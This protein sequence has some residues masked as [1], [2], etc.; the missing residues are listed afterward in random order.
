MLGVALMTWTGRLLMTLLVLPLS[1]FSAKKTTLQVL[2]IGEA[3]LLPL[4]C[5]SGRCTV[6][7]DDKPLN[8]HP[9]PKDADTA[10]TI[11][12]TPLE[13]KASD[14][15]KTVTIACPKVKAKMYMELDI[16]EPNYPEETLSVNPDLVT[17]PEHAM[18]RIRKERKEIATA[19]TTDYPNQPLT[20]AFIEPVPFK[21]VTSPFGIRR[22]YNDQLKGR[23]TGV[24]LRA[25]T[26]TPVQA[27]HD[28][29]V[30]LS[31]SNWYTGGHII[32]EHGWGVTSSYFHLSELQV[33]VGDIIKQGQQI[34]LTGATGRVTGPHLHWGIHVDGTPVNPLQFMN[35]TQRLF[36][37]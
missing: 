25:E 3:L 28:G 27:P 8:I 14:G 5:P 12:G 19:L 16:A 11:I 10:L 30:K 15:H 2:K 24:D 34:A 7:C 29:I 20:S 6:T 13:A 1:A 4:P 23:H 9:H 26:G 33:K 18:E 31:Q 22:L 17:P 35:D 37:P 36:F 21:K 32:I